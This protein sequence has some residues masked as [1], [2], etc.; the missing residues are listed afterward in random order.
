MRPG[1]VRAPLAS[2]AAPWLGVLVAFLLLA[3]PASAIVTIVV[4][5]E[6]GAV[7]GDLP[8]SFPFDL[9]SFVASGSQRYQQVYDASDFPGPITIGAIWFRPDAGSGAAFSATISAIEVRLS[10]TSRTP[11]TLSATFA[12][13]VGA[14]ET[15]VY[16]GALPLSSSFEGPAEGPKLFDIQIPLE[17]SFSYDPGDGNLLLD[18]RN[19]TGEGTTPFNAE[20]G[21]PAVGR[22]FSAVDGDVADATGVTSPGVGLVTLFVLPEPHAAGGALAAAGAL[23]GLARRRRAG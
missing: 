5:S 17:T 14:D 22:V 4:P 10:T 13:N 9:D 18:V 15:V 19:F 6:Q 7:E 3:S 8:N 12:D 2:P 16:D 23:G 20:A 21:S 1:L 11:T